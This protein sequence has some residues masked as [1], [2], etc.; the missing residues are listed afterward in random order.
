[1]I[2]LFGAAVLMVSWCLLLVWVARSAQN[3]GRSALVWSLLAACAGVLG[4]VTG[5]LLL[6]QMLGAGDAERGMLITVMAIFTP[7]LLLILPMLAVGFMVQREPIKVINRGS[8]PVAFL[9]K[10]DGSITVDGAQIRVDLGDKSL[11][12]EPQQL[13]RVEA[14]GECVRLTLADEDLIALPMGKPATPAG[15]RQ[16]SLVLAKRLRH[17]NSLH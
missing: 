3:R 9:G 15:R 1:M 13:V 11:L 16:Q 17:A 6:D 7:L 8:W 14:D 2:L 12:L 4:T 10:G 5:V